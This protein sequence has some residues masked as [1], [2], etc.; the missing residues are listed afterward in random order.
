MRR[1]EETAGTPEGG[2]CAKELRRDWVSFEAGEWERRDV[3]ESMRCCADVLL[4]ERGD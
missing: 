3:V 4:R 2:W 1:E